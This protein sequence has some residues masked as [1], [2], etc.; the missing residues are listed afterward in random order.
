M[1]HKL[2]NPAK[3]LTVGVG[4]DAAGLWVIIPQKTASVNHQAARV[5]LS[6]Q[7]DVPPRVPMLRLSVFV[8]FHPCRVGFYWM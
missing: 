4:F 8:I 1:V 2:T 5:R 6:T 3:C 7:W